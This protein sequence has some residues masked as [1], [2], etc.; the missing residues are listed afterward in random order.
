M[1]LFAVFLAN[2]Q[3]ALRLKKK[4]DIKELFSKFYWDKGYLDLFTKINSKRLPLLKESEID[5]EIELEKVNKKDAEVLWGFLYNIFREELLVLKKE[6][7]RLLDKGFI[8]VSKLVV[9]IS[10]LFIYKLD[11]EFQ[12]CINYRTLNK[13]TRKNYYSLFLI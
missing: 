13:I 11:K 8:R 9:G 10:V 5:Y 3:K 1:E 6:L 4:I 7:I 2:I 12:F